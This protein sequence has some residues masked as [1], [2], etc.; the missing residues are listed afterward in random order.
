M[1]ARTKIALSPPGPPVAVDGETF[2]EAMSHLAAP[3]TVVTTRDGQGRRRGFTAS[4]VTSVSLDPPLVLVGLSNGSSCR[5]ALLGAGEFIV[6]VLGEQHR[7]VATA[8][9]EHGADRFQG[10][11]FDT[12]PGT[13]L[14]YLTGAN[15]AFRCTRIRHVPVGDHHL[16]I[17]K[18]TGLVAEG[19]DKPLLW[20]RRGFSTAS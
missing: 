8:F 14:P 19:T 10:L 16:V 2:R 9:A 20:Y 12:W 13:E 7:G 4:S 1:S 11:A 5:E 18:L 17:G 15:A 6:N 3:L